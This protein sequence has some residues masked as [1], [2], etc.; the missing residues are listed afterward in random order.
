MPIARTIQ[1]NTL[2]L[3]SSPQKTFTLSSQNQTQD[4]ET[5]GNNSVN[6]KISQR[7]PSDLPKK[8]NGSSKNIPKTS[9]LDTSQ[10]QGS[11]R[12]VIND[13]PTIRR[14]SHTDIQTATSSSNGVKQQLSTTNGLTNDKSLVHHSQQ[15]NQSSPPKPKCTLPASLSQPG[16]VTPSKL[17]NMMGYGLQ[18]QYL[19]MHA[20]YLYII[21]CRSREKFNESHIITAIH[22]EDALN[23]TVYISVVERFSE[24]ILYDEKGVFFNTTTEMRRVSNRFS[25][26][27]SRS[28]ISLAGGFEAFRVLFPFFCTQ[29]DIRSTVDREKF[30]T[31]YPSVV[32]DNQLYLGTGHQ[33]TNW[34]VV[35]D[36]KITHI[37]N[38]S[39]E[40]QC[41]F[42]DKIKYLYIELEDKEDVL[43]KDRFDET[44]RF[45]NMAF[46][47]PSN[48]ILVHCNLGI[49][50]SSTL[51]LA[52]LM[53]TYNATLNEAYKFLRHRRPIVCP[54]M[55]FLHQLIEYEHD[56]FS[57]TY[58]DP[59][60]PIFH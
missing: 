14:R 19:L 40:H 30:L 26:Q 59:N 25:P 16:Y 27:G 44:I 42:V 32:L 45:M 20:H 46:Q 35:R 47:N 8:S 60:D 57:Y 17:F 54:N 39:V 48:R 21:D 2:S 7:R 15:Q 1:R 10:T 12:S 18:N 31:I 29:A 50:R 56:L 53:K 33:A 41:V 43:L 6:E 28:C 5:N 55:G 22:W 58:T 3:P 51:I 37:I 34:K 11:R 36:L 13:G 23:G 4:E 52:Y 49:S 38:I 9:T 24:I